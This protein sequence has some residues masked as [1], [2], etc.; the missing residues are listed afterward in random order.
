[1]G[2]QKF[3]RQRNQPQ[4]I[5]SSCSV[6]IPANL[7]LKNDAGHPFCLALPY[8]MKD[9]LDCFR[10]PADSRL[11]LIIGQTVQSASIKVNLRHGISVSTIRFEI[12]QLT[13]SGR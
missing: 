12:L 5:V 13:F 7:G 3:T 2:S 10:L 8:E 9:F 11:P 4:C 6:G 1:M